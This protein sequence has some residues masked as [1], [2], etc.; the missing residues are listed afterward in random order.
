MIASE[1]TVQLKQPTVI[2]LIRGICFTIK[3]TKTD[4]DSLKEHSKAY[5]THGEKPLVGS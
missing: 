2:G 5:T 1:N 3:L 4:G